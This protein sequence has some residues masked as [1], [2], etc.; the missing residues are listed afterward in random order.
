MFQLRYF[1]NGWKLRFRPTAPQ[2]LTFFVTGRCNADCPQCFYTAHNDPERAKE[3]LTLDE[4]ERLTRNTRHLPVVLLSGGEPTLRKDLGGIV[5]AFY[6]NAGTRHITLPTNGFLPE[7]TESLV[8]ASLDGAPDLQFFVQLSVDEIGEEHDRLRG[9]PG[10]FEKLLKT[11]DLLDRLAA[12]HKNLHNTFC[13]TFSK[14]NQ[15]RAPEIFKEISRLTGCSQLRIVATRGVSKD[16]EAGD[17]E[18]EAYERAI[19]AMFEV[20]RQNSPDRGPLH[21][22]F[23]ARQQTAVETIADIVR[24]GPTGRTC[25]AGRVNA[26][27]DELGNVYPCELRFDPIGNVRDTDYSLEAIFTSA[28]ADEERKRIREEK[29]HCTHETNVI[30]QVSFDP[31]QIPRIVRRIVR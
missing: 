31:A 21:S 2:Y 24:S 26:V 18:V 6:R 29:C 1:A 20:M 11:Y 27:L 7:R 16:P 30:T 28:A 9:V 19:K 5:Q 4:I 10:G 14:H 12:T 15:H 23:L 8:R 22:I 17:W 13:L 25:L 3:E